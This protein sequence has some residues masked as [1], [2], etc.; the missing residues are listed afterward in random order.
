MT[1][2]GRICITFKSHL[3]TIYQVFTQLN[4]YLLHLRKVLKVDND[5]MLTL[6]FG[7]GI[8]YFYPILA[9]IG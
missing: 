7:L 8:V 6:V 3:C 9:W 4:F 5:H 2:I 1:N